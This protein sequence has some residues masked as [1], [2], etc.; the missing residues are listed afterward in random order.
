MKAFRVLLFRTH[1]Q[2]TVSF[3]WNIQFFCNLIHHG[4]SYYIQFCFF[5]SRYC[6]KSSMN[7]RT[8]C[9][10]CFITYILF[11]FN[12]TRFQLISGNF[13]CN[14]TSCHSR[15]NNNNIKH[16]HFSPFDSYSK[17]KSKANKTTLRRFIYLAQISGIK[18]LSISYSSTFF[19]RSKSN[20]IRANT[21][22]RLRNFHSF[23][24]PIK[25]SCVMFPCSETSEILS[26]KIYYFDILK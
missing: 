3:K 11:L 9:F 19:S 22:E 6:I 14:R 24:F 15:T 10:G 13:T 23:H 4:I 1:N 12:Y 8:V 16:I 17:Q 20:L 2:R 26:Q 7:D 18:Y 25:T 5:C 21:L